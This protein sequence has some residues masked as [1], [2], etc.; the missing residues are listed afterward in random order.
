MA[1]LRPS[2]FRPGSWSRS[3]ASFHLALFLPETGLLWPLA[4]ALNRAIIFP[5]LLLAPPLRQ[6]PW[7]TGWLASG[8]LA[9]QVLIGLVLAALAVV[10]YA[11]RRR[12]FLG[13]SWPRPAL[14]K[15][16]HLRPSVPR[17]HSSRHSVRSIC[18]CG[19][20]H[21]G[22]DCRQNLVW[23]GEIPAM[24][25]SGASAGEFA[26]PFLDAAPRRGCHFGPAPLT[27]HRLVRLGSLLPRHDSVLAYSPLPLT[28]PSPPTVRAAPTPTA[29]SLLPRTAS[30][31]RF[32]P[33]PAS[34]PGSILGF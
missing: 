21:V 16:R 18:S 22:D 15:S 20:N 31:V 3:W 4:G 34:R 7:S 2:H 33:L 5:P 28:A 17:G 1:R 12:S 10:T 29:R 13:Y 27:R 19:R 6:Q 30:T 14:S 32:S 8:K 11:L 26:K 23:A 9:V 24:M 25:T